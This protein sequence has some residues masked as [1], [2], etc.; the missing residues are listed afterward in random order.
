MSVDNA[1]GILA[2]WFPIGSH[3]GKHSDKQRGERRGSLSV[4]PSFPSG[5]VYQPETSAPLVLLA[6]TCVFQLPVSIAFPPKGVDLDPQPKPPQLPASVLFLCT[7]PAE[8]LNNT[9]CL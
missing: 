5:C 2:L 6:A 9:V 7:V 1:N 8:A 4:A 3:D